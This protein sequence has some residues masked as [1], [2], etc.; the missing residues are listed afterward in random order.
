[1]VFRPL[2]RYHGGK[3]R[4]APWIIERFPPHTVYVEPFGGAASVLLRKPRSHAE[5][6]N[7]LD[8]EIVNLFRV[9]RNPS[10]A[11]EL[12]RS[13]ELTPFSR[14]E[15][16]ES[17]LSARDPVEQARRTLFRSMA[18][19]GSTLTG[20]WRTGFRSNATRSGS[21][22]ADDWRSFPPAIVAII[23][24]LRGVIIE[25]KPAFEII[26]KYDSPDTLH[27]VDPPYPF[28]TRTRWA[29]RAYAHEMTDD[30]HR[31]LATVLRACDGIVIISG[32]SCGLYDEELY[33]DWLT[34]DRDTYADGAQA[35]VERLWIS[36]TARSASLPLFAQLSSSTHNAT[37][38]DQEE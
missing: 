4:I 16:E 35:R 13:V 30:E 10:Q 8:G 1:M 21:T 3:W 19:F 12:I 24:R 5:I 23:E 33:P 15:F 29:G 26:S 7:D 9:L 20:P 6:Y 34:V 22:P 28:D 36:P 25:E 38:S 32:Y 37:L 11:Q 31:E 27:Y 18:G 14:Q 17:Y 2:L